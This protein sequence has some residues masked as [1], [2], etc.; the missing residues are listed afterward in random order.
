MRGHS[1]QICCICE[2]MPHCT[3]CLLQ[4]LNSFL[5]ERMDAGVSGGHVVQLLH[6]RIVLL[7]ENSDLLNPWKV[8]LPA[9]C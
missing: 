4:V 1:C 6:A 2:V 5:S 9:V 3:L 7:L 8:V